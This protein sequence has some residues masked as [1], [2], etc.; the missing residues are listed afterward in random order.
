MSNEV[1]ADAG[2][3]FSKEYVEQLKSQLAE[4][5]EEAAKLRAFKSTYDTKQR[6]IISGLQ[7]DISEFVGNLVTE[8]PDQA[9]EMEAIFSWT[10][11]C[12]DSSSLE[13]S[14]PLAR[15]LSCASAQFKRSREEASAHSA[16]AESLGSTMKELEEIKADRDAKVSRIAELEKLCDER[17]SAAEKMQDELAKAGLLAQKFD[18]S[19]LAS[20][21]ANAPAEPAK[22]LAPAALTQVSSAAS[23]RKARLVEDELMSFVSGKANAMVSNRV[24]QSSTSHALLGSTSGGV[25]GEIASAIRGY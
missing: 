2:E 11:N 4:R 15:V 23:K 13:S 5:Q 19:K 12:H 21:E 1:A 17:Q 9:E 6:S 24:S 25:D 20:R 10:K 16:K 7:P 22:G 18:F 3:T 14:M 8:N